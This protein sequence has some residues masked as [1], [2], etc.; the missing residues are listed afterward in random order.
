MHITIPFNSCAQQTTK[1]WT[2]MREHAYASRKMAIQSS[3]VK[4]NSY[5]KISIIA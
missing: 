5:L 2:N 4:Q 1:E 3:Y